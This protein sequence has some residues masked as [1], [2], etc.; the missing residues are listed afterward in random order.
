MTLH[1][2]KRNSFA[3]LSFGLP[4]CKLSLRIKVKKRILMMEKGL[5]QWQTTFNCLITVTE[6]NVKVGNDS[7]S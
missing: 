3:L 7:F 4:L 5:I 6:N 1:Y 2:K